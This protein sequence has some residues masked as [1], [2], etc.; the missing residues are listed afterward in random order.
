MLKYLLKHLSKQTGFF[1]LLK[2]R[3]SY[4]TILPVSHGTSFV[5]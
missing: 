4:K 2:Q 3:F 1:D 5:S